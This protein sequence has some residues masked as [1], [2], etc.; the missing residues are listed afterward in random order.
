LCPFALLGSLQEK[1]ARK[2]L[3]KSTPGGLDPVGEHYPDQESRRSERKES[4]M[5]FKL[6]F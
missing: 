5:K 2:T 1:A 6:F 4:S 3:V